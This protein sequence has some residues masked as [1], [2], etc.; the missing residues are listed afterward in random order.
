MIAMKRC[1]TNSTLSMPS[2]SPAVS[3]SHSSSL[4]LSCAAMHPGFAGGAIIRSIVV[5]NLA[6]IGRCT[7]PSQ[8]STVRLPT[9][10]FSA[11]AARD[12]PLKL[13]HSC[14]RS[15]NMAGREYNKM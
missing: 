6:G 8:L 7:F 2:G 11:R 12:V 5:F 9:L 15:F 14:R 13:S 4:K 1:F 3:L 10:S